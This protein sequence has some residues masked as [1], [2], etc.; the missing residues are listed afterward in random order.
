MPGV[1]R[2]RERRVLRRGPARRDLAAR[3]RP[4][5]LAVDDGL[6]VGEREPARPGVVVAHGHEH[7]PPAAPRLLLHVLD[8][9]DALDGL[10]HVEITMKGD[11]GGR[12][13]AARQRHRRQEAAALG[14]AVGAERAGRHQAE[15]GAIEPVIERRQRLA[16]LGERVVAVERRGE[17]GHAHRRDHVGGALLAP[18]PG[19][20]VGF[21]GG[22]GE[23]GAQWV[24]SRSRALSRNRAGRATARA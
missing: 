10:A 9:G 23:G 20:D 4:R 22:H 19:G 18:D 21:G 14:V 15:E 2:A 7:Q 17:L 13:H 8:R 16:A 24:L 12:P 11:V 1:T 6:A 5:R 3:V